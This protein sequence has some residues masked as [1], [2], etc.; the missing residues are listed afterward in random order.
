M[1]IGA[2]WAAVHRVVKNWTQLT[3]ILIYSSKLGV[4]F[5]TTYPFKFFAVVTYIRHTVSRF[6]QFYVFT[7]IT[8]AHLCN[9]SSWK[10]A[11]VYTTVYC[12]QSSTARPAPAR[13]HEP[14]F[15]A[16]TWLL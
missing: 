14:T 16:M 9:S 3:T 11:T 6:S 13:P 1:D 5:S 15:H 7:G 12:P 8:T 4:F 10:T 2:W